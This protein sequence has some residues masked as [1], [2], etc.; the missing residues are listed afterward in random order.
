M[1][2]ETRNLGPALFSDPAW[3]N[4]EASELM[5]CS[6]PM[7]RLSTVDS[8]KQTGQ[9]LCLNVN[10]TSYSTNQAVTPAT[11]VRVIAEPAAGKRCVLGEVPVQADGSFM[12]EV[13][14]DVPLGLEALDDRGQLLRR[15]P[16]TIWV[17]PG[18]NRSC[19]GCHE[20]HNHAPPNHRP[21]AVRAPVPRLTLNPPTL[22]E[23]T[24]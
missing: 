6:P 23:A 11:H 12:A 20:P 22:A 1:N 18:E 7:G 21:L 13:P 24:R 9:I 8:T 5:A 15:L 17:R 3:E 10:Y 19:I 4:F 2:L 16:A 14:A